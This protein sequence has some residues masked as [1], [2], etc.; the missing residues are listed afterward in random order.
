[1]KNVMK[2]GTALVAA[3]MLLAGCGDP[4]VPLTEDEES[5][6]V[7][8]SAGILAKH[9][10][11]QQEGMT[12]VYPEEEEEPEEEEDSEEGEKPDDA[13]SSDKDE[14]SD[15]ADG[16]D[17][18][19]KPDDA[20]KSDGSEGSD[21]AQK[22]ESGE[23]TDKDKS[24]AKEEAADEEAG[25]ITLTKALAVP[26]VEF[27]YHDYSTASN[28]K[29]GESFSLDASAGNVYVML[30]INMTNT[31]SQAAECDVLSKQPTFTLSLNGEAGV[32]NEMTMLTNDLSTYKG[33]LDPGQTEA[34][35]LLFEVPQET[36]E[37]ISTLQLSAQINGK[38]SEIILK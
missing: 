24:P 30:N 3:A 37:N 15:D 5:T 6:V 10:S 9:N 18:E 19:E 17:K 23:K 8:Y 21:A 29:Q 11:F 12:A 2:I 38:T 14:K 22:P 34:T 32:L 31:G 36:A 7:N 13:D 27:S 33:V 28:Y 25:P 4:M 16:S 26:K 35:I 20:G 1:M